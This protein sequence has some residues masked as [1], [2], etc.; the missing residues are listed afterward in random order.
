MLNNTLTITLRRLFASLLAVAFF[1][2]PARSDE[3]ETAIPVVVDFGDGKQNGFYL[4]E[5]KT[6]QI[7]TCA[8]KLKFRLSDLRAIEHVEESGL[9]TV[10]TVNKDFWRAQISSKTISHLD[11]KLAKRIKTSRVKPQRIT[12]HKSMA[13]IP[14]VWQHSITAIMKDGSSVHLNPADLTLDVENNCGKW[15]LPIGSLRAIKP[16][17]STENRNEWTVFARFPSGAVEEFVVSSSRPRFHVRDLHNNSFVIEMKDL[18]GFLQQ[19]MKPFS[20][21]QH[22]NAGNAPAVLWIADDGKEHN[23]TIP[24][25]MWNLRTDL[26][27]IVLP[28][29]CLQTI[30]PSDEDWSTAHV[31]TIFGEKY[32]G[33]ISPSSFRVRDE[34]SKDWRVKLRD[35]DTLSFSSLQLPVPQGW[36]MWLLDDNT[37]L[38]GKIAD[39]DSHLLTDEN[40]TF[41]PSDIASIVQVGN[42]RFIVE[43]R[44]GNRH[45]CSPDSKTI[46]LSLL[47]NGSLCTLSWA[48]ITKA[49][50]K[51]MIPN[52][53]SKRE[54]LNNADETI[55]ILATDEED[56][57]AEKTIQSRRPSGL[58][59]VDT[60][61]DHF[62][63]SSESILEVYSDIDAGISSVSTVF[64]DLLVCPLIP[65]YELDMLVTNTI[66]ELPDTGTSLLRLEDSQKTPPPESTYV[67][68]LLSGNII[69]VNIDD[70]QFSVRKNKD[71]RKQ[72]NINTGNLTGMQRH[73]HDMFMFDL[74]DDSFS[75]NVIDEFLAVQLLL[76]DGFLEIPFEN[77]DSISRDSV[78]DLPPPTSVSPGIRPSAAGSVFI[79]GGAYT[80][81]CLRNDGLPDESPPHPV[82]LSSFVMD[83]CEVT[84]AQFAAFANDAEYET[85][86]EKRGAAE[87]WRNPG[88]TQTPS[89]PVGS[90]SW[91]DAVAYCNWRSRKAHL[92]PCYKTISPMNVLTDFSANG[93]RLPTEAE[94]EFAA[95]SG[96]RD[97]L[98]PWGE[99]PG[100]RTSTNQTPIFL[101]NYKQWTS[102][103]TDNWIW[104]NPVKEFPPNNIGIYGMG[105]NVWEWCEDWYSGRAYSIM[106]RGTGHNPCMRVPTGTQRK[107]RV[108]RGGSFKNSLDLLRCSSRGNG[109]PQAFSPHVGFRCVRIAQETH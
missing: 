8:G 63:L 65:E 81:G 2:I 86:A 80:Q 21:E 47:I 15:E 70:Q 95:R 23:E 18:D 72:T 26:G 13:Q 9:F 58:L 49:V 44:N 34:E 89:D 29:R 69:H 12:I 50:T 38:C 91:F 11:R 16:N 74:K 104:T 94:W 45:F 48:D 10:E 7:E 30:K 57:F 51:T 14:S 64:G 62:E 83:A 85:Q 60:S 40:E 56:A 106:N 59:A 54:N 55:A 19:C 36:M 93:F 5:D 87:T 17:R 25:I 90:V 107:R 75:G 66:P 67:I 99:D 35:Q 84:V 108:M 3:T 31:T 39:S 20:A 4:V 42:N 41:H 97:I 22:R 105:G 61:L 52:S 102:R 88:F 79:Q 28:S 82:S 92:T 37:S 73:E 77:I 27:E 68:R 103:S 6:L 1:A 53:L 43:T 78:K 100:F 76:D 33:Q 24:S 71:D 109:P 101:A 96:N 98:Y 32:S 46:E